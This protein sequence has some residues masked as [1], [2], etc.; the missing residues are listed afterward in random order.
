MTDEQKR[1]N[2]HESMRIHQI[3]PKNHFNLP[4]T[5]TGSDNTYLQYP[6]SGVINI[7]EQGTNLSIIVA[8]FRQFRPDGSLGAPVSV[9]N[10]KF[11]FG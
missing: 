8:V 4:V 9:R 6:V 11:T 2:F 10:P 5:I 7:I 3:K 1:R